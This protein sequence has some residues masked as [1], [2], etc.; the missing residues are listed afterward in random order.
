MV[1]ARGPP[2]PAALPG[3]FP[4]EF[5]TAAAL[6]LAVTIVV[7]R[8]GPGAWRGIRGWWSKRD[9]LAALRVRNYR[10]FFGG[11]LLTMVGNSVGT[12]T[13]LWLLVR[14]TSAFWMTVAAA[15]FAAPMLAGGVW[16]GAVADGVSRKRL[17]AFTQVAF[18]LNES[19]LWLVVA[20]GAAQPWMVL[21]AIGLR[22]VVNAFDQPA[23]E[24][25][26]RDLVGQDKIASAFALKNF[27]MYLANSLGPVVA[28]FV[29]SR[30]GIAGGLAVNALSFL[31]PLGA[32][33]PIRG[34]EQT[35][36]ARGRLR[37][38][39]DQVRSRREL[40]SLMIAGPLSVGPLLL[41]P[42][43]LAAQSGG[44]VATAAALNLAVG[45]GSM[46]G[47]LVAGSL[48][49]R[50]AATV[51]VAA[52]ATG[53]VELLAA[54]AGPGW[55]VLLLGAAGALSAIFVTVAQT[56]LSQA[57]PAALQARAM[58][59]FGMARIGA[60]AFGAPIVGWLSD[61]WSARVA[62]FVGGLAALLAAI[63]GSER[64]N[65]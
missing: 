50:G 30:W 1:R 14:L 51:T 43:L 64:R 15:L 2:A 59:L 45:A 46:A 31:A 26:P 28:V 21:L 29:M 27:S 37:D 25:F 20:N 52:A 32:L 56:R 58:A 16:T 24:S 23:R 35:M 7:L 39:L 18:I 10:W 60:G 54:F 53:I 65:R 57:A 38:A 40:W 49:G 12:F 4:W 48:R 44:G 6:A 42:P 36:S 55:Q 3:G 33:G 8:F 17:M 62:L 22:G 5:A 13:D 11:Q 63:V 9:P 41:L 47:A 19:L 34:V 61:T